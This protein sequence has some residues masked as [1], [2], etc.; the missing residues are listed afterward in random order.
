MENQNTNEALHGQLVENLATPAAPE[1]ATSDENLTLD[2]MFQQTTLPSLARQIFPTLKL[3]GPTGAIFNIRKKAGTTDFELVRAEVVVGNSTAI[4]TGITQ[5]AIQDIQS[6]YGEDSTQIIGKLLRGLAN[7]AENV[8]T[9]AFLTAQSVASPN[10]ILTDAGNAETTLFEVSQK[11]QEL[12]LEANTNTRRTYE[13]YA[14]VPYKALAGIMSLKQYIG[15]GITS[16]RGLFITQIGMTKYYINPDPASVTAFVGL[17]D[18]TDTGKSGAVFSPYTSSVI[19]S[20]NPLDASVTYHLYNRYAITA[21]PLHD[22]IN[23][24]M[25]FKFDIA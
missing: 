11:V 24:P 7:D 12:V 19:E 5:E 3:H 15:A 20:V 25:L 16:E 1:V 14:V 6:Q 23:D 4:H 21:S 17:S 22:A 2:G 9:L 10:I 8:D 13:A 18:M